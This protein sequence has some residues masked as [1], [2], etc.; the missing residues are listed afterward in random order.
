MSI[1]QQNQD[2]NLMFTIVMKEKNKVKL[3]FMES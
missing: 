1:G 3:C 2:L